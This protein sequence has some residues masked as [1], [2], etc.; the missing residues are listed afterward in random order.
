ML[1]KNNNLSTIA[2]LKR[3][4]KEGKSREKKTQKKTIR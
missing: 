3:K 2:F 1:N 4:K